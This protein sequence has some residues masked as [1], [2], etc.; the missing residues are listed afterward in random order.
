MSATAN[1][2]TSVGKRVYIGNLPFKAN[3]KDIRELLSGFEVVS[4]NIPKVRT[5]SKGGRFYFRRL[6][7][8]FVELTSPEEAERAVSEL[9]GKHLQERLLSVRIALPPKPKEEKNKDKQKQKESGDDKDS[10]DKE[11]GAQETDNDEEAK[12]NG[13]KPKQQN[14]SKK[15]TKKGAKKPRRPTRREELQSRPDAPDTVFVSGLPKEVTKEEVEELFKDLPVNEVKITL[16]RPRTIRSKKSGPISVPARAYAFVKL[17]EDKV[18][19]AIEQ[20]NGQEYKEVPLK[21]RMAKVDKDEVASGS[22]SASAS[23]SVSAS[24]NGTPQPEKDTKADDKD[25][26]E[27]AAAATT[28]TEAS[29]S[30]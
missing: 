13:Q 30:Q 21:V 3:A 9:E 19:K 6:G 29:E 4:V 16:S 27:A 7:Y 14:G 25:K 28:T 24:A 1:E 11:S 23:A 26:S 20:L 17:P 5:P 12:E 18:T 8:A 10:G 15:G 22:A 2:S